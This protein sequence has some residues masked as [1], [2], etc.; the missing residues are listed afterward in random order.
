MHSRFIHFRFAR[1]GGFAFNLCTMSAK[2]E[3]R[4]IV[5]EKLR[6]LSP[7][8]IAEKSARICTRVLQTPQWREARTVALFAAQATEPDLEPLW[9]DT[10]GRTICYPRVNGMELDFIAVENPAALETSRW[11]L[12]E[13]I[14]DEAHIITPSQLDLIFVPGLAFTRDGARLGRGGG[15][16]DRLLARPSVRARKIGV[17]FADQICDDLPREAHDCSVDEVITEEE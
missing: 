17:C 16:Y 2:A 13:P 7:A 5:R 6:A 14:H 12:R 9:G 10:L 15:F 11:Q 4:K 1:G 3:L 8:E